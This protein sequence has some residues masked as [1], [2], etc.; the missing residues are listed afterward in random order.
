[1]YRDVTDMFSGQPFR[2]F[3]TAG[4]YTRT[5]V[6]YLLTQRLSTLPLQHRTIPD[7]TRTCC[8]TRLR[9]TTPM[10]RFLRPISIPDT[11]LTIPYATIGT[12]MFGSR[13]DS[14]ESQ[15]IVDTALD[16]GLT[17]FDTADM[18][19]D[20]ESERL[21]GK[22]LRGKRDQAVVA[23]KVGYG[24][25]ADGS[26]EGTSRQ[27]IL[28]AIEGSLDRLGMDYVDMYYLHRPDSEAPI[29]E[30]LATLADLI[31][32]GKI[33]YYAISNFGG[34]RSCDILHIC[35]RNGWPPPVMTQMIY[36]LL[37]RQIEY[38]YVAF[39]KAKNVHLTVY[40]P[41]AGGLLTGK[42]TSLD[43]ADQGG[44][45][46]D[47]PNY[48]KRYW[49]ERMMTGARKLQRIADTCNISLTHLALNWIAQRDNADSILLG[50]S[51]TNQLVDCLAAGAVTIPES[52]MDDIAAFLKDFDGT[53]A[54][55]AR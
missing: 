51:N 5:F 35:E 16:R 55:Y 33:R 38:E 26:E 19:N 14:A 7:D 24:K 41:L 45:F 20:G 52:A 3:N 53:N 10:N 23:T 12:M 8:F 34:W 1:M 4:L 15:R 29:E 43:D 30:S 22:A 13:A 46:V 47:N 31:E 11:D 25:A 17:F 40:N 37:V 39:C 44:R 27:A 48:R 32:G 9:G 49:S 54:C 42:Y 21:L 18:Y 28:R 36:N 50:P 6:Y 2:S